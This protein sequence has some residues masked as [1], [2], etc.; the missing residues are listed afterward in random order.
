MYREVS[1]TNALEIV[2]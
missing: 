2:E 1:Y